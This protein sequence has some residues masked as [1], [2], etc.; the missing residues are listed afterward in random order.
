MCS[1]GT[2]GLIYHLDCFQEETVSSTTFWQKCQW[3]PWETYL[4]KVKA[5]MWWAIHI[6]NGGNGEFAFIILSLTFAF[7]FGWTS[8]QSYCN[9]FFQVT[10]LTLA[11]ENQ[12]HFQEYLNSNPVTSPG[13]DLTVTVL[14]TGFWP[15]YKSS[16]LSLPAE[17]VWGEFCIINS[18][19]FEFLLP[20]LI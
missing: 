16:D 13:I 20:I 4:I 2:L 11:K 9:F 14:T 3:W 15:S 6:K 17:M 10:D 5:A 1:Q 19:N 7:A 12:N 8:T 18:S